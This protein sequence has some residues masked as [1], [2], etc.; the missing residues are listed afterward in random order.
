[1]S[2]RALRRAGLASGPPDTAKSSDD[3]DDS[4]SYDEPPQR[5][6]IF[7]LLEEEEE[8]GTSGAEDDDPSD[9]RDVSSSLPLPTVSAV[10][11]STRPD[12]SRRISNR[13]RRALQR[14]AEGSDDEM[15]GVKHEPVTMPAAPPATAP[16]APVEMPIDPWRLS[17]LR[18]DVTTELSKTFGRHTIRQVTASERK[19]A[20]HDR[21]AAAAAA[22]KRELALRTGGGGRGRL[23]RPRDTW[24]S[25]AGGLGMEIDREATEAAAAGSVQGTGDRGQG[26]GVAAAG[27]RWFV[28]TWSSAYRV[29]CRLSIPTRLGPL[30][31]LSA[32]FFAPLTMGIAHCSLYPA[33]CSSAPLR[34]WGGDPQGREGD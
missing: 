2:A 7:Q 11:S 16:A 34:S 3:D 28:F 29:Y 21:A 31:R 4:S 19:A 1:M 27:E 6:P 24:P 32:A 8:D 17:S 20:S 14:Q 23:I 9:E 13:E 5:A 30:P 22:A 26:T 12:T 10:E 33:P 15:G 18:I 25:F